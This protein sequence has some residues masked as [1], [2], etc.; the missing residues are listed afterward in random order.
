MLSELCLR[1]EH[2]VMTKEKFQKKFTDNYV[3]VQQRD[4]EIAALRS[5]LKEVKREAAKFVALHSHVSELEVGMAV[6][7]EEDT[8]ACHFEQMSTKL[9][10]RIVDV[11][12]DMDNN[13]YPHK[14][15]AI[16]ER[17]KAW[18]LELNIRDP[19]RPWLEW[20][21]IIRGVKDKF[22]S[23]VTDFENRFQPSLDQVTVL[24]YS[25]FGSINGEMLLSEVVPIAR[26]AT[27]RRGLC[28]PPFGGTS[29]S[30]PP[31][32]SSLGVADYQVSTFILSDDERST[33]QPP[34]AHPHDDMFDTSVLDGSGG[35]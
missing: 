17:R 12:H 33:N 19:S 15:T 30:V 22:I 2:K 10:A 16:A 23:A 32:S 5:R 13:L 14:F 21:L 26:T 31:H 11:R 18:R 3:V 24:I 28:P 34:V 35:D 27:V 8:E 7:S 20:R 1:Y 9:D 25:E 4:A 6:K 29:S